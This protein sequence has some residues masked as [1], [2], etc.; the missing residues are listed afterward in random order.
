LVGI[1]KRQPGFADAL[2]AHPR[3]VSPGHV[4]LAAALDGP[5]RD[6]AAKLFLAAAAA[7][8]F[9]W[10]EPLVGLLSGLPPDELHPALRKQWSNYGLRD[11]ILGHLARRPDPSDRDKFLTGLDSANAQTVGVALAAIETLPPPEDPRDL[12]PLLKL[13]RR[14]SLEPK[15]SKIR[16]RAEA[17]LAAQ[18]RIPTADGYAA[19][20]AH[21]LKTHPALKS[22]LEGAADPAELRERLSKVPWPEG[23]AARGAEVFRARGCQTYH[24][25]QGALGPTLAGAASR[26][27]R[28]DLF[29]AI[30][31]P[32]KDVAPPYRT[33]AFQTKSGDVYTGIIA[34]DS[35]DGYIV[36]TGATTT[37]RIPTADVAGMKPASLSLMP[38]DLLKGL[39]ERDLADLYAYLR[40]LK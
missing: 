26:F 29:E 16:P 40:S 36:Q 6:A 35:A 3:F 28:D 25:A 31:N 17:V 14:L 10:S 7:P 1:F 23:D 39:G 38:N 21:F 32:S 27:S 34:F 24:A 9:A 18:M 12:L 20:A 5:S 4:D 30:A 15:P 13:V 22:E 37:V 33:T 2:L 11:A 8:D 19:Y